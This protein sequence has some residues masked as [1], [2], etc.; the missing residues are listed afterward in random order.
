VTNIIPTTFNERKV[1]HPI[2]GGIQYRGENKTEDF[3]VIVLNR[4]RKYYRPFFFEQLLAEAFTSVIS[5]ESNSDA[6]AMET[7]T[8]K[9]PQVRFLFPQ[10]KLTVG[11]MINLGF[12]E[13]VAPYIM[14][15][16][17]DTHIPPGSFTERVLEKI[18]PKSVY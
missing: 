10:E 6:G 4:G 9:F 8:A 13:T 1:S 5:I 14:V 7:L 17:N 12:A 16:W 18:K 11:E 2:I 3:C 15:I